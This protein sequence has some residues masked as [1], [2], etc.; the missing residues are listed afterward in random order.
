MAESLSGGGGPLLAAF[1]YGTLKRGHAN[2]YRFCAGYLSVQEAAA[3]GRLYDL[4]LGFPALVVPEEDV[5]ALGT[6]DYTENARKNGKTLDTGSPAP[7]APRVF[8]ELF[9]FDD[10][11]DRLPALD[12]LEG[13]VPGEAGFYRRVLIPVE[14]E[15][16]AVLAWAY[17][18]ERPSGTH[19]PDGRWPL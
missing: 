10:P 4:P 18:V 9:V 3:G 7:D 11:A 8:G 16:G 13:F 12:A 19:L 6:A 15:E 17:A 14:T 2:H 1:F 5:R